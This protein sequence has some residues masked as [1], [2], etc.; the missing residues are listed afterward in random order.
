MTV[1]GLMAFTHE[2]YTYGIDRAIYILKSSY[3][4]DQTCEVFL[5]TDLR[6]WLLYIFGY[7]VAEYAMFQ[8]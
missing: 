1:N 2:V 8:T 7:L 4:N 6:V 5:S 3:A